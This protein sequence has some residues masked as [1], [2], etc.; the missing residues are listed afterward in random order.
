MPDVVVV[1]GGPVGLTAALYAARAGLSVEVREKRPGVVDK[2]CGEGLMP[3]AAAALRGLGVELHGHAL[4]GI[5]YRDGERCAEAVF[6]HGPGLGVRRTT[7]HAALLDAADRAGVVVRTQAVT[8][9]VDRGDHVLVEGEP[10]AY[11]LAAD[12]LHSPLRRRLGLQVT[13]GRAGDATASG[14][15]WWPS[16]GA[17][18][19]RCTGRRG[20]RRT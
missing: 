5:R 1:G 9:V 4:D 10:A 8:D 20:P 7:L 13:P 11:V 16:R 2:A 18:S 15:T 17:A 14:P 19:S 12:G 3:G 6:R